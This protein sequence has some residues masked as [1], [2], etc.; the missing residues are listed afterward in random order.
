[1]KCPACGHENFEGADRCEECMEPFRDL[2]VPRPRHG[3]QAHIMMDR[4]SKIYSP[5]PIP[6][7]PN[8]SVKH[9]AA[10]MRNLRAG[11]LVVVENDQLVGILSEVDLLFREP[12]ENSKVSDLM[13]RKPESLEADS[14]IASALHLMSVGGYRHV[15]V[16]DLQ[17]VVGIVSIKDVLRYL[18][19][20]L[21]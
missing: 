7:M 2:D 14:S 12:H 20:H 17:H 6:V 18:K 8:D 9:A 15:P 16:V 11:A 19:Q 5:S 4:V 3:F 10:I 13:T 1:M 21:L